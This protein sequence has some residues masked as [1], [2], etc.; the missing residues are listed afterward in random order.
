[1][2][3]HPKTRMGRAFHLSGA[4]AP[5]HAWQKGS[6]FNFLIASLSRKGSQALGVPFLDGNFAIK[7]ETLDVTIASLL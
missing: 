3:L 1:M 4:G 5:A 6:I 2:N 7:Y